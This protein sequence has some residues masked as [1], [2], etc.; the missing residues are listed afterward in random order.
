MRTIFTKNIQVGDL[1]M[2]RLSQPRANKGIRLSPC[3]VK[4]VG[5]GEIVV[6]ATYA[7]SEF[8]RVLPISETLETETHKRWHTGR[9]GYFPVLDDGTLNFSQ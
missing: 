6:V 9:Q 3:H 5:N 2:V 4:E 1:L 7:N 8:Q